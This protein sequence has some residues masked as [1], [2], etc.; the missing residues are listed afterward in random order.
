[1]ENVYIST[2]YIQR[3]KPD[4]LL[5]S[6]YKFKYEYVMHYSYLLL[7]LQCHISYWKSEE[8]VGIKIFDLTNVI[9]MFVF[10]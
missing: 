10:T 8:T 7:L 1:M 3:L 9:F 6:A 2:K 5:W 4:Q